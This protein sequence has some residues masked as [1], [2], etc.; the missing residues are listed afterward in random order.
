MDILDIAKVCHEVNR[1]Y[2]QA[3]GDDS[4]PSWDL[5]EQWRRDS[6]VKGVEF[7]LA[8][9][10]E[11]ISAQ[12]DAWSVDKISNGW[13]WGPVKDAAMKTHPCLVPYE[14]LPTEQKAKDHL[15]CAVVRSLAPHLD[16]A[17]LYGDPPSL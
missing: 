16:H 7:A 15:F 3:V 11:K 8:N 12:H 13:V 10:F 6:A 14:E 5:A 2:C 17:I 1:S 4:Q 9:P